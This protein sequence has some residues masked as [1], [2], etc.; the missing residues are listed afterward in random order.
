MFAAERWRESGAAAQ[1]FPG[2]ILE[3]KLIEGDAKGKALV[4]CLC[5]VTG[6]KD[7]G[8][9]YAYTVENL[10]EN[11]LRFKWAGLEG[12]IGPKRDFLK[13]EQSKELMAEASDLAILN[14]GDQQ[15]FIIRAN[16]WA[17]PK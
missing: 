1:A 11:P 12:E 5:A 7:K 10:T 3:A 9:A 4:R 6:S 8:Y 17:R 13:V 14:F 15:E 2:G 16:F